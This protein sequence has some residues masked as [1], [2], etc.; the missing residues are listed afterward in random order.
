MK[1][2]TCN[3]LLTLSLL[4]VTKPARAMDPLEG[5]RGI[6]AI[7]EKTI[8]RP[9]MSNTVDRFL[10]KLT[11]I[12]LCSPG[13]ALFV[14]PI[15]HVRDIILE[16]INSMQFANYLNRVEYTYS[17]NPSEIF[18][19]ITDNSSAS[20]NTLEPISDFVKALQT[21]N[22]AYA[23]KLA[24]SIKKIKTHTPCNLPITVLKNLHFNP[25]ADKA[26]SLERIK[27]FLLV[28]HRKQKKDARF[29]LPNNVT[30]Q[31]LS[32]L[33]EDILHEDHFYKQMSFDGYKALV[34]RCPYEWFL[35]LAGNLKGKD[36]TLFIN[37]IT[38][39]IVDYRLTKL[40]ELLE[41]ESEY[42]DPYSC[43]TLSYNKTAQKVALCHGLNT[44][45]TLLDPGNVEQHREMLSKHIRCELKYYS[46]K[47]GNLFY[48]IDFN[49]LHYLLTEQPSL[50]QLSLIE[51][52]T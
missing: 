13:L 33:P 12:S 34:E 3:A 42:T 50:E 20:D 18:M 28:L 23:L 8:A 19:R 46:T 25:V 49:P 40:K 29:K 7:V 51:K 9:L 35:S 1:S 16:D 39:Y 32:Y 48:M 10:C 52:H 17:R 2:I 30:Q 11:K 21:V 27:T 26:A 22:P 36:K 5:M 24:I 14:F 41:D 15:V 31:I 6:P 4:T 44:L 45:V 47:L 37:T 43:S 38:P